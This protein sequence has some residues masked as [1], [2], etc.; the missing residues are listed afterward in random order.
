M[1]ECANLHTF[2]DDLMVFID[3]HKRSVERVINIFHEFAAISCL[4]IK[5]EM[6]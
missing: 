6:T 1:Q 5:S 2:A 3:G 4:R